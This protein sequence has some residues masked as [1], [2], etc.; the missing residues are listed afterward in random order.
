MIERFWGVVPQGEGFWQMIR[1]K[2]GLPPGRDGKDV[3]DLCGGPHRS[4]GL[5]AG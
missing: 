3:G 4:G 1:G 2:R 5:G